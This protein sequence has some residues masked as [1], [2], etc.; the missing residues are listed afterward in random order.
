MQQTRVGVVLVGAA[1]MDDVVGLV[2][3][4]IVTTLGSGG[5][6]G[7]P[8]ARPIIASF[9]FLLVTLAVAPCL[10][11][12]IWRW[13][14]AY[15][16]STSGP[17]PGETVGPLRQVITRL[18]STI[19][20]LRFIFS[21]A[22]LIIFVTIASFIDASVL[23]AAFIAGGV[24]SFLWDQEQDRDES[25]EQDNPSTMYEQYYKSIMDFILVPFF[26]VST[27]FDIVHIRDELSLGKILMLSF[28]G[29]HHSTIV[30]CSCL[31]VQGLQKF[32]K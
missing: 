17:S 26:F 20:H 1:M 5:T 11:T 14:R 31:L 3:V 7:W 16:R 27:I 25:P 9:G 8:I 13:A 4:N 10:L 15:R 30:Y 32:Q 29:P 2:M 22:V 21:T 19:P 18:I 23:F 28:S 12:P 6:G 24:V